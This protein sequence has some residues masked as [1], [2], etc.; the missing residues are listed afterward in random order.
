MEAGPRGGQ[1]DIHSVC[2]VSVQVWRVMRMGPAPGMP[3]VKPPSVSVRWGVDHSV[4]LRIDTVA[5]CCRNFLR[6]AR[7]PVDALFPSGALRHNAVRRVADR[8]GIYLYLSTPNI[9]CIGRER[10]LRR[11]TRDG[12]RHGTTEK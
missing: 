1:I 8:S 11:L 10:I 2:S 7:A 12:G 4:R 3:R 6:A 5:G 9:V